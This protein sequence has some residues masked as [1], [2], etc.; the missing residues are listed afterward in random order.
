VHFD[1]IVFLTTFALILPAE[2]PDKSF[3]MTLVLATKQPRFAVWLGAALAFGLQATIAVSAGSLLGALPKVVVISVVLTI[4]LVGA[5]ILLRMAWKERN[6][7]GIEVDE[8][9]HP[10]RKAWGAATLL[11][12]GIV[13]TAEWGDIT[14]IAAAATSAST[15]NPLSVGLGAWAAEIV[16]AGLGVFIGEKIRTKIRPAQLHLVTGC[17]MLTLATIAAFELVTNV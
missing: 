14:Q 5:F 2:L 15:G 8:S 4:F 9:T 11:T 13:F 17:V 6:T 12:F 1:L 16:V 10:T 3:I 7:S